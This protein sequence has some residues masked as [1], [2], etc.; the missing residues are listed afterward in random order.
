MKA[1]VT[2]GG[3]FIGKA[4]VQALRARGDEVSTLARGDY[5][6]LAALGCAVF[7]GD[8]AD[9][10]AVTRAALGC[11]VVFHVA[12]K[13]GVWGKRAD[14]ERVNVR[15]TDNVIDACLR[16]E[17][18]KLVFTSSPSV[19]HAGGDLE[20]VDATH[21]Y[22]AESAYAADY[23]RTKAI[24]EKR[25]RAAN[26]RVLAGDSGRRLATVSLR[27]HLVWG[28]GDNHLVPRIVARARAGQLRIVGDGRAKVDSTY[29]DN[30]VE[31]HLA[32]EAALTV[33]GPLGGNAYFVSNGEPLPVGD[34][35]NR[36]VAAAGAPPV[37]RHVPYRL[38]YLVGAVSEL[39]YRV[40]GRDDE[41][42]MTRFV[43]EQL[44]TAHWFD[45]TPC[46]R[47][48]GW[49]PRVSID[50]GMTRLASWLRAG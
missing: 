38:A 43:A 27:P 2:G 4:I 17:V 28:P 31:A 7:R 5:P 36:I 46:A 14:Y 35:I 13:A 6:E 26:G 39:V 8:V 12:A 3:G 42:R 24:A 40:L 45:L 50:E 44:A 11:D 21:P 33:E 23:P 25:V 47:D 9:A 20:G 19:A 30:A 34:L 37:T 1:L 18:P 48:F 22:P 15:G 49:R 10:S 32:A 16:A 41:P 29:I